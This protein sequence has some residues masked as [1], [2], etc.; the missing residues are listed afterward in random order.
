MISWK[1]SLALSGSSKVSSTESTP[2]WWRRTVRASSREEGQEDIIM[3][4]ILLGL[5]FT[6]QYQFI[7]YLYLKVKGQLISIFRYL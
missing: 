2:P 5:Q 3:L 4:S 6:N 7:I 1:H